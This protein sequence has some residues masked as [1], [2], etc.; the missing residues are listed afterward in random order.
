[1]GQREATAK[2]LSAEVRGKIVDFLW[3]MKKQ[4]YRPATIE[5]KIS[6]IKLLV[7]KGA[8]IFDPEDIKEVI[9]QQNWKDSS[10]SKFADDYST[11]LTMEGR[12]WDPPV[13]KPERPLPFIPTET[14]LD[15]LIAG[16]GKKIS[17]FLQG[18]KETGADPGEL[19]RIE[20]TDLDI[21]RKVVS[22]NHPVKRHDSRILP[23]SHEWI[24]LIGKLSKESERVFGPSLLRT[25][26]ANYRK[27]RQRISSKLSNPRLM[28]IHFTTF[29]HWKATM[30]YHRTKDIIHVKKVLGHKRIENTMIY[31]NLEQALFQTANDEF[32]VK[33]AETPEEASKLG[34]AGFEKFDEFDGVHLYRKRK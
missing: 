8:N 21:K 11:F 9:A 34:E 22:I 33:V 10:K 20:W 16:S 23:I 2:P 31:I 18:L 19:W 15:L 27:T 17:C 26:S 7:N 3:W 4:G 30:E 13:Y 29:R 12:M 1:M 5:G 6:T 25:Y 24:N 28:K 32:H 14:E